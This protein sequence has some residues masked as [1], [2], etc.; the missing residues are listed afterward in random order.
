MTTTNDCTIDPLAA[1]A[2]VLVHN[3]QR[4][5]ERLA[6]AYA[7]GDIG[8]RDLLRQLHTLLR[9]VDAVLKPLQEA[10]DTIREVMEKPVRAAGGA[11]E[12]GGDA[13]VTWVEPIL[14]ESYGRKEVDQLVAELVAQGGPMVAVAAQLAA[15]KKQ[16]TRA[17]FVKVEKLRHK[18]AP[19]EEPPF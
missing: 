8:P 15:L 5:A 17:G 16:S 12:L 6:E 19:S 14:T 10:R 11:V 3:P 9:S 13:I 18:E 1:G 2:T 4:E 7:E